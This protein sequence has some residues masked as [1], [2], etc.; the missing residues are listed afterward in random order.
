MNL[1]KR[2]SLVF[3]VS[4]L[5]L[6]VRAG[7]PAIGKEAP[8]FLLKSI[9]GKDTSLAAFRGK[10]VVLEWVNQGCPFVKKHYSAGN[11]QSLQKEYTEKGV[12]W[13]SICSSAEGKQGHLTATEWKTVYKE[14]GMASTAVLLDEDGVVGKTYGAKTTPHLFVIDP[15][16][17][18][19][20]KGAMDDTPSTDPKDIPGAKNYVRAALENFLEGKPVETPVT[21]PYGCGVKYK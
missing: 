18:L 15:Q 5:A 7:D 4:L 11:M 2:V 21:T 9:E 19:I 1:L 13:L 12:V 10:P 20:Y 17:L 8:T 16:G 14:K 6:S 3:F